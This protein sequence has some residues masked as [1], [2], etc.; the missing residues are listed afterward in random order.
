MRV[1]LGQKLRLSEISM[2]IGADVIKNQSA[3]LT[4]VTTDTREMQMGDLFVAVKGEKHNGEDFS[5][6]A[7]KSGAFAVCS[8]PKFAS[9]LYEKSQNALLNIAEYYIQTLPFILYKIG[10][11]GSVGKT[12]TKEFLN[13]LLKNSYKVHSS[14]GNYNSQTGMPM[15]VLAAESDTQILLCEMGM[16]CKGEISRLSKC[17]SPTLAVI[18]NIGTSHIGN[19]GSRRNIAKAKLEITDGLSGG[20]L[21]VPHGEPLL[22]N[23]NN[24]ITFSTDHKSADYCLK[25]EENSK[26]KIY[27]GGDFYCEATFN[28]PEEHHLKCLAAATAT[29]IEIG[30]KKEELVTQISTITHNNTRQNIVLREKRIFYTD[31]YNSSL[32]SVIAMI[33]SAKDMYKANRKVLVLGDILELGNK[34]KS[35]HSAIG[36]AIPNGDFDGVF[37]FGKDVINIQLALEQFGFPKEKIFINTDLSNPALTANQIRDYTKEGDIIFMKASRAIKLERILECFKK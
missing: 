8:N 13:I 6:F 26:I 11:T 20:K 9:I 25:R 33:N 31:F 16:S 27:K 36:R 12:T 19:L 21:I 30:I 23:Y 3:T 24:L 5:E 15:S 2:A 17:L 37:L 29:A 14:K 1:K 28:L 22:K 32:E 4:Y 18:T 7:D 35:I 10:I 34:S